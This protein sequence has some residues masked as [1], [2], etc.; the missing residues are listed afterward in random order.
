MPTGCAKID[1]SDISS[2]ATRDSEGEK[3]SRASD[4]NTIIQNISFIQIL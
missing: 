1:S 4:F 2:G 3:A